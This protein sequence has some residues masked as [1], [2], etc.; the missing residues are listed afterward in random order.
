MQITEVSVAG[1]RSA[2]VALGHPNKPLRFVLFPMIHFGL[3][4]F[5]RE[6]AQRLRQCHLV[7]AEGYDGPSSVG[8]AYAIALRMT[9]QRAVDRLVHQDIDFEAIGVP[10]LW[11]ERL[12]LDGGHWRRLPLLGWLDV[13]LLVP[14]LVVSMLL[15]GRNWLLRR[16]LEV[17]DD[18]DVR[19]FLSFLQKPILNNRD[20]ELLEALVKIYESR[21]DEK[22]DVAVV[23]GAAHMPAVV[24][25]LAQRFGYRP[26]RGGEWLTAI[27]F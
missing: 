13:L 18:T 22:I 17:S 14:S 1:V 25:G 16:N 12:G 6:V 27:D 20:E 8:L 15:G 10:V 24:Q 11:P 9:R 7:V 5:Y 19:L 2:V 3:P 21:A 23:Y 26:R 4:A